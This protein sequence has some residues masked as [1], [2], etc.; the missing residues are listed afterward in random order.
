MVLRGAAC[1]CVVL[2]GSCIAHTGDQKY[3]PNFGL[4]MNENPSPEYII[5]ITTILGVYYRYKGRK[6]IK[7]NSFFL[8][9]F[10]VQLENGEGGGEVKEREGEVL[11]Q[12][13]GGEG[14]G[15][16]ME[17]VVEAVWEGEGGEGGWEVV[18]GIGE[19][20]AGAVEVKF[21]ERGWEVID[22]LVE[23]P[24]VDCKMEEGGREVIDWF[25]EIV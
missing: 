2:R 22:R 20:L 19:M 13:K 1:C 24:A 15:E 4:K 25:V 21:K 6:R 10:E 23:Y 8:K 7:R 16:V 11:A 18:D 9:I 14:G 3:G 17:G 5:I 12:T